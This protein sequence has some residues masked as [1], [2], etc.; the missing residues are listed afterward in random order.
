MTVVNK[1]FAEKLERIVIEALYS[2]LSAIKSLD[3]NP[4]GVE[5]E[6][7]GS[8]TAF[9]VKNIPGPAFNTVKGLKSG[10]EHYVEKIIDYYNQKDI[11]VRFDITPAHSS[12]ELLTYLNEL[13]F[14]QLDFHTT[15]Y[16]P[17]NIR[18]NNDTN[19]SIRNLKENEFGIFADIY[20]KGFQMPDFLKSAIAQ[21]NAVL[22]HNDHWNFYLACINDAPAG[23]GVLFK[24]DG[25][26]NLAASATTPSLRNKGV[27][28]ALIRERIYQAYLQECEFIVGQA[29]FASVS[30]NNMERSG[31]RIAYTQAVWVKNY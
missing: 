17:L 13:G 24:K 27:H 11:P 1:E 15:L 9:S 3:G 18:E 21:N 16:K 4:M 14:Y 31:M 20:T 25:V 19:V 8:A 7:F 28:R 29:K 23:I 22:Y 30:Q 26:A 10:D 6:Q 5:I 12:P 2:R